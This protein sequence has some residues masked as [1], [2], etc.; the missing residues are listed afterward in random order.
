MQTNELLRVITKNTID[1]VT[2]AQECNSAA[3]VKKATC[4]ADVGWALLDY[5]QAVIQGV[6]QGTVATVN[7]LMHPIQ[8]MNGIVQ[9]IKTVGHNMTVLLLE[10]SDINQA[11]EMHDFD[12]VHTKSTALNQRIENNIEFF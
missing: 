4:A 3:Q 1:F 5:S 11:M 6:A 9:S 7:A 8:T 12:A 10:V 2:V